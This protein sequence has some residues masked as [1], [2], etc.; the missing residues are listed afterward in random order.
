MPISSLLPAVTI[1]GSAPSPCPCWFCSHSCGAAAWEDSILSASS[2]PSVQEGRIT[3]L[4]RG[5]CSV[6]HDY[7]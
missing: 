5:S 4:G 7:S 6:V 3:P 2:S 1:A